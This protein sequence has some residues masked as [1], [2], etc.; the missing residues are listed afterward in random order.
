MDEESGAASRYFCHMCSLII[1]P[2]LGIEEVKCPHCHTGFVEEMAGDR[3]AGGDADTRGRAVSVNASD[4]ALEREVSLWAPVLMDYLA[5]SSGR[6]GLDAGGGGGDLA[7]F[8]RRQYRN[9]ALLQLLNALQ[10]GD[11]AD[12][13]RERVVLVSPSDARAMLMG[14]ERGAGAGGAALGP[15]GLTLG[16]LFL[17]PGLDLLLEYLA[18]TDPSRQGTPPARKEAV[19]A[20]PMVRARE[21]F[22][23]PVCLDEVAAGGEAREMP[24]KHRFHDPCIVPW[25][26]MHS[27]CPVCRHQLPAEE[28]AEP[29][30]GGRR[31]ADEASGNAHSGDDGRSSG[32]RHWFSWPFGGLFSQR[33]NGSSSSSS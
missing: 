11:A 28:P 29:A 17:G 8:A 14:Q 12:A 22:T 3:R 4:A 25:L 6:H 26:E 18:E 16:D 13:G 32:R 7:A 20:L 1:R 2:E 19:A 10:E 9:I 31:A 27:S 15:G 21:A 33:S 23:C 30:G 5:A 24:C